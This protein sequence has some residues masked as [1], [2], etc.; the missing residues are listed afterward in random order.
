MNDQTI[1]QPAISVDALKKGDRA[2]FSRLVDLYS[3]AIYR[4]ALK[5][6]G[7]EQDAEDVLQE[8]FFKALRSIHNFEER[9]SL[10]T[11]LY[12][13]AMNESLMV[14]RKHKNH[15]SHGGSGVGRR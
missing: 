10:S 3:P 14:L 1:Q 7:R 2:E 5:M 11:W 4:L 12:R 8:T 9:S 6:L 15:L 13:I